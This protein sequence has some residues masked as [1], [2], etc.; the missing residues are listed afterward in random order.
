[1]YRLFFYTLKEKDGR[2]KRGDPWKHLHIKNNNAVRWKNN[3]LCNRFTNAIFALPAMM[4]T[5]VVIVM[6][7]A[8]AGKGLIRPA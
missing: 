2:I 8:E 5:P 6:P 3:N 4:N 1:L 7:P